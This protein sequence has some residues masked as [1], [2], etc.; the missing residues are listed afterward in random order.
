MNDPTLAQRQAAGLRALA[1]M[2]EANPHLAKELGFTLGRMNVPVSSALDP[3]GQLAAFLRAGK[4][5]AREDFSSDN[6]VAVWVTF[7]P[8][9]L[10]IYAARSEVCE[11]VVTGT[12]TVETVEWQCKPLLAATSDTE[13]VTE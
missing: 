11:R 6:W 5:N 4:K 8:V 2:I 12:E 10:Y 1:D 3:K 9:E 13:A 7:G